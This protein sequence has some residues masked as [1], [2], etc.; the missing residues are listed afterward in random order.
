[1]PTPFLTLACQTL[2]AR[3]AVRQLLLV[4]LG[5]A[6]DEL[7][8]QGFVRVDSRV[9]TFV[10]E[11]PQHGY[12]ICGYSQEFQDPSDGSCLQLRSGLQLGA[13]EQ[14]SF[15][16][17][18]VLQVLR[19]DPVPLDDLVARVQ[20]AES[21]RRILC[22]V[23]SASCP[24]VPGWNTQGGVEQVERLLADRGTF[25]PERLSSTLDAQRLARGLVKTLQP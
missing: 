11:D 15:L 18:F 9:D 5:C 6:L 22:E 8:D 16:C 10:Q 12:P 20:D 2:R 19:P 25:E 14:A 3:P 1:M 4:R 17:G 21:E 24:G 7:A 13:P 23:S